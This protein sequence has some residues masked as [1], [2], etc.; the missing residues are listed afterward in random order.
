LLTSFAVISR[1]YGSLVIF[2]K[3]RAD[4]YLDRRWRLS[5]ERLLPSCGGSVHDFSSAGAPFSSLVWPMAVL[6]KI[7]MHWTDLTITIFGVL[8]CLVTVGQFCFWS[9]QSMRNWHIKDQQLKTWQQAQRDR[10]D[11]AR[12]ERSA[13]PSEPQHDSQTWKGWR[14]FRV[15]RLRQETPNCKSIYLVPVDDKPVPS[16]QAGQ[17]LTVSVDFPG[18]SKPQVRCYSLS[19]APGELPYRI[20]VKHVASNPPRAAGSVSRFLNQMLQVGDVIEV[21]AP[22]GDFVFQGNRGRPAVMLAAGVGITPLISMAASLSQTNADQQVLFF[23]GNT[24]RQEHVL[25]DEL[26]QIAESNPNIAIVSC[27]SDP[28]E[29]DVVGRDFEVAGRIDVDVIRTRVPA[30]D[31]DYYL[32]GPAPFMQSLHQSLNSA[33]VPTQN[34]FYE[35]FGPASIPKTHPVISNDSALRHT[36]RTGQITFSLSSKTVQCGSGATIL[37]IGEA[38]S[39]PMESGCRAG[40]CGTCAVRVLDGKVNYPD[41]LPNGVEAEFCLACLAHPDG[42]VVVEA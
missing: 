2:G 12:R 34:I 8:L 38:E 19:S 9:S 17:Y 3:L 6:R 41:G 32:C 13:T 20:T 1:P 36:N 33:G 15:V 16:F 39:I 18:D 29:D 26:L 22:S 35:A 14:A 25:G 28:R 23:Y 4:V 7:S 37:E 42:H 11:Q 21:K 5:A 40:S 30:L 24:S 31:A 10:L 27:Y